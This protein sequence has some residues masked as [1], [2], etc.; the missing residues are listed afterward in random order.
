[1]NKM[2]PAAT[3]SDGRHAVVAEFPCTQTQ[4]R[5]WF[6]DQLSPGN[7]ALNVAVRWEIRGTFKIASIEAAFRQI[8]DRHEILRTRFMDVSGQPVQQVVDKVDFKMSVIDLRNVPA[9]Q[10]D[11]RIQSISRETASAPFDL[12]EPGL[13][14]VTFLMVEND[15][16]FILI[17]AHQTCFDG[18][19]IRVLGREVGEIA[20]AIDADRSPSLPDLPL[21]YGDFALWQDEYRRSYGFEAEK[22]YWRRQLADAPYFEVPPD[23]PRGHTKTSRGEILSAAMPLEFGE[24]IDKAARA[25]QVSL[26]SYGAAVISAALARLTGERQI[27]FGTQ[28]AGR[29]EVDLENLIG[30]FINNLVLRFDAADDLSFAEHIRR[31]SETVAAALNHQ[32]MP[33]NNLVELLNPVRDPSRNPLVSINFNQQKAF[34]ENARYGAFE[35][36]SAPSQSPGVIY[37][38]NFIMIGRPNGWRM[39]V[40][41]NTDLFDAG[42][43]QELL[44]LWQDTYEHAL[45]DPA[46]TLGLPGV[47][48]RRRAPD[49]PASGSP[50]HLE[51]VLA[52]HPYVAEAVAI[53][54]GTSATGRPY[55][56]VVPSPTLAHP[57][58]ALPERL[59]EYLS[60]RIEAR[61]MPDGISVLLALPRTAAGGVDR[62]ALQAPSPLQAKERPVA[63]PTPA[64]GRPATG[65]ERQLAEIWADVLG[66][67]KVEGS[68]DF[69]ALGGHSLLALRMLSAMRETFGVAPD[70]ALL[71]RAPTLTAFSREAFGEDAPVP[72]SPEP[73][74]MRRSA[75]WETSLYREGN[76]ACT[77]Y[78]LNHPFLY[79]RMA[80]ELAEGTAVVNLHMFGAEIDDALRGLPMEQIV[81]DAIAAMDLRP[82]SGPVAVV[83]LCVNG[84]LAIELARQLRRLGHRTQFVAVIDSWA[85]GYFR[86]LPRLRQLRWTMEKRAKRLLYFTGKLI[87]GRIRLIDYLKEFN[88]TLKL[89]GAKGAPSKEERQNELVTDLLVEASRSYRPRPIT[90]EDVLLFRS[91]AN[92]KRAKK[93]LFGWRGFIRDDT[94]AFDLNGWHEDSLSSTGISKLSSILSK[95]LN[96]GG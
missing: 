60:T 55:G 80:N 10:R 15:R 81:A 34:L 88:V 59:M 7:P 17:T 73:A 83:G 27:L 54:A 56:F 31:A 50:T 43:A 72:A 23:R 75:Y 85:P 79:Y 12:R 82:D 69:F 61:D 49:E 16:G 94:P 77:L 45:A 51:K 6:L 20:S 96:V 38:L 74:T 76:G 39:S 9:D 8:V 70:L 71:F 58:E 41:Y 18:W 42:T 47:A 37:D 87:G 3:F 92:H 66:V 21:Q 35:L 13:F 91:Q 68:D 90:G 65:K 33:F 57:V 63:A 22:T 78:T 1:M 28:I 32:K 40:E 93:L 19:S 84:I 86:S 52:E 36:I 5:C 14:R 44:R 89:L 26:F 95:R 46:A 53:G 29:D 48:I 30:V 2:D 64:G 24:R 25:H 62:Q 67:D 4:L 11:E